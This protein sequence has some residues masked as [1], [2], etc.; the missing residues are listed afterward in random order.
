MSKTIPN[1]LFVA[2][3]GVDGSGKTTQSK[4]L[5]RALSEAGYEATLTIEPGGTPTGERVRQWVKSGTD[6][7]PLAELF[8]FSAARA[9]LVESVIAPA[10]EN[11]EVVVCDRYVYSTVAYQGYGRGLDLSMIASLNRTATGG[12]SPRLVVLL[13]MPPGQSAGRKASTDL[14]RIERESQSFHRRVRHGYLEQARQDPDRWLVLDATEP[15]ADIAH[16]VWERV[17][18]ILPEA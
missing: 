3:E 6:I 17:T 1:G 10:M 15:M 11:G 7:T 12:L 5:K 4:A 2:F 18:S 8:L 16:A 14:D 13:D 9:A